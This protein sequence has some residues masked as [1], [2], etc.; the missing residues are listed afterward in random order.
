MNHSSKREDSKI[1]KQAT[2]KEAE[3]ERED[4][5]TDTQD[6][7]HAG[8]RDRANEPCDGYNNKFTIQERLPFVN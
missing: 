3:V 1:T 6:N 8:G 2:D 7:S 5:P 4:G